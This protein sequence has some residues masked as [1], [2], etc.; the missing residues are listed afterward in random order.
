MGIGTFIANIVNG[1]SIYLKPSQWDDLSGSLF[2]ARLDTAS[3]RLIYNVYNAGIEYAQNARFP[4]EPI[5][6]PIQMRHAQEY[7]TGAL[8]RPH[9]HWLQ[10]QTSVP[11][12]LLAYK[13]TNYGSSVVKETDFSNYTLTPWSSSAFTHPGSGAFA[14]I[15]GFPE[16]DLSGATISASLDIALFRDSANTS[17]LFAGVDPVAAGVV[18]KYTDS[19]VKFNSA[20]SRQEY[21]K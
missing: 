16:I 10:E 4:E 21:I 19:H 13:L 6:V 17:G 2:A 9:I 18:V 12:F 8:A 15:T 14:Q 7:G 20:G 11:N 1:N 3:G 5:V